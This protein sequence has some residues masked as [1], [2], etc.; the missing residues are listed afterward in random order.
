MQQDPTTPTTTQPPPGYRRLEAGGPG[1]QAVK[2]LESHTGIGFVVG[3]FVGMV[4]PFAQSALG[5]LRKMR[6]GVDP[7]PMAGRVPAMA[8]YVTKLLIGGGLGA[9]VG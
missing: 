3:L 8:W 5:D 6:R 4:V 7:Y 9:T 1:S 2:L